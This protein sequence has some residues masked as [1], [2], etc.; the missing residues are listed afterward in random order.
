MAE[1]AER[2][3]AFRAKRMIDRTPR[4]ISC[5]TSGVGVGPSNPMT[6]KRAARESASSMDRGET[7]WRSDERGAPLAH[8]HKPRPT[9]G[10]Q[11]ANGIEEI[12]HAG[13]P[14]LNHTH[15]PQRV[16]LT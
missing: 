1:T 8:T 16:C 5:A 12:E 9:R 11:S 4:A 13:L 14:L 6:T 3:P 15:R 7:K 10:E 2:G